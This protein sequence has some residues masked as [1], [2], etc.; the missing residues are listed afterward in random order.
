[1]DLDRA[2]QTTGSVREFSEHPVPDEVVHHILDL[3]RYAPSGGNRQA[4]RVVMVKDPATRRRV[5][6]LYLRGW[7]EYRAMGAAGLV[8]WAP[9]T[10]REAEQKA[11][12]RAAD[13]AAEAAREPGFAE[14]LDG[15]PVMLVLLADLRG[16]A[17]VDRD[18]ER[19]TLVGGGSIY[20]LAWSIL[21]A[22]H[23]VGLGGV[24]TTMLVRSESD[25]RDLLG[26]P[27]EWAVAGAVMLGYPAGG[28]RPTRLR[29]RPVEGFASVDRFDGPAL[30]A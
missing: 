28:N 8:P 25:V 18:L 12:D 23:G 17:A 10:D 2:L 30:T 15:V 16:L 20:P 3:A 5:R 6:D 24:L 22:A 14:H 27:P 13:V 21:L 29:R 11:V 9:I 19:Y 26:I 7:Y 4:W 1:M